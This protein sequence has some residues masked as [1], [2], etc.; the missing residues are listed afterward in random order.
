M[1]LLFNKGKYKS[2][3]TFPEVFDAFERRVLMREADGEV[4]E[5]QSLS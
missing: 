4:F 5:V 3:P 2:C 1:L